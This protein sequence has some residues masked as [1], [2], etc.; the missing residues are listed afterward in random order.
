[1]KK[2]D[3]EVSR[4]SVK[5]ALGV[6]VLSVLMQA[7]FLVGGWW[8]IT[9]LWGNLLGAGAA[10]F[11]FFFMALTIQTSLE[12]EEKEAKNTMKLSKSLRML[13]LFAACALGVAIPGV[14]NVYATL[15]P[16]LFPRIAIA[17]LTTFGKA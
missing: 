5:I 8:D 2:I 9:V 1:M 10:W 11:N 14:F 12:K 6:A 7:V 3:A 13:F 17:V 16:L 15:I 4:A